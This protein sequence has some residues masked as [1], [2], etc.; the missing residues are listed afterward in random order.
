MAAKMTAA[1]ALSAQLASIPKCLRPKDEAAY[2]LMCETA[3]GPKPDGG[4][5]RGGAGCDDLPDVRVAGG[6]GDAHP[7]R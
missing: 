1:E 5:L 6:Y 7:P 4:R 3:A 2:K